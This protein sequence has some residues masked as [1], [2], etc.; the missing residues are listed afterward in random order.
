ML[1][2]C[3]K[4]PSCSVFTFHFDPVKVLV[5]EAVEAGECYGIRYEEALILESA[6]MRR[7]VKKL[8]E[9]VLQ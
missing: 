8:E 6:M 7:R 3:T 1:R 2:N 4:V 9:Q 5:R